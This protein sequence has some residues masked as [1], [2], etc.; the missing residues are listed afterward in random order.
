M[1]GP[2]Q[3]GL[4]WWHGGRQRDE[5]RPMTVSRPGQCRSVAGGKREEEACDL[6]LGQA[7][8]CLI[9]PCRHRRSGVKG[10]RWRT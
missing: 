3:T 10:P 1:G 7:G 6:R 4:P 8:K 9:S 5:V 2:A